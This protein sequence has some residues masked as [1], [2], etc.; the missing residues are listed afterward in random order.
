MAA[1]TTNDELH[2]QAFS[3]CVNFLIKPLGHFIGREKA[4]VPTFR[5]KGAD[6]IVKSQFVEE[7]QLTHEGIVPWCCKNVPTGRYV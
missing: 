3:F 1:L 4:K 2:A 7:H 6:R 5:G